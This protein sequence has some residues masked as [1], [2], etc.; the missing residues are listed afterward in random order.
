MICCFF[1]TVFLQSFAYIFFIFYLATTTTTPVTPITSD[2]AVVIIRTATLIVLLVLSLIGNALVVLSV[3]QARS[4]RY[5]PFNSFVLSLAS[6]C[7]LECAS[8]MSLATG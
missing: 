4:S 3:A 7:L 1:V 6:F 2:D 8:T 5:I